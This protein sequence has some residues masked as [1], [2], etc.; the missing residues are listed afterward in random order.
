MKKTIFIPLLLTSVFL[1]SCGV[2]SVDC[3]ANS[4]VFGLAFCETGKPNTW[5]KYAGTYT[6]CRNLWPINS[7]SNT[8][9]AASKE[10]TELSKETILEKY[11]FK[12]SGDNQASFD[13]SQDYFES[14]NCSGSPF[15]SL[16]LSSPILLSYKNTSITP[17]LL[18]ID[19]TSK[20]QNLS[21]DFATAD[22]PKITQIL[23]GPKLIKSCFNSLDNAGNIQASICE[24]NTTSEASSE[25][26]AFYLTGENLFP[27][28]YSNSVWQSEPYYSGYI[29]Q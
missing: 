9:S 1:T 22:I 24:S 10:S 12:L 20:I 18:N 5:S 21:I 29:K 3:G 6:R 25:E 17:A 15:A 7:P 26:K 13:F 19:R 4:A 28:F 16:K 11:I 14:N 2:G 23:S 8:S 27:L